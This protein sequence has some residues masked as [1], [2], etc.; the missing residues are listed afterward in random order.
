LAEADQYQVPIVINDNKEQVIGKIM[1]IIVAALSKDFS[2]TAE[3]LFCSA[4]GGGI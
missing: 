1:E 4:E 3:D 2:T